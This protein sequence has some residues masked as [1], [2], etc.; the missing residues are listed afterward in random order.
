MRKSTLRLYLPFLGL[1]AAQA[2][3]ISFLPST[4]GHRTQ[5]AAGITGNAAAAAASDQAATTGDT[6]VAGGAVSGGGAT[7]GVGGGATAALGGA[8][9]T[10]AAATE[11]P[12]SKA[13]CVGPKQFGGLSQATPPCVAKF[14][15]DNG[16]ATATGVT[17]DK[18]KVIF[19]ASKPNDQVDAILAT[20]GLAVPYAETVA[21]DQAALKYVE[22][23]YELYG[24]HI[25]AEFVQGN[26][27]TTP[28]DYDTCNAEAQAVAKKK[29]FLII[30]GTS[31]YGSVFDIWANAGIV[32]FG[33]WQFD[34]SLF[35]NPPRRGLRYD[36]WMDGTQVGAHLAEYYCKKMAK[37][38]ADHSGGV[39]HPTIGSRG[40][41]PRKL[42]IITPEIEANV[43]AAKSV[44]NAVKACGGN[45]TSSP[46]TYQSD[47]EAATQQT[48]ATVTKLVQDKVTTVACMCDPI[49]PA[50][51][52]TGMSGNTYFPE[53]LL[54]GTQFTDADLVGR[55]YDPQQMQHAFG[56]STIPAQGALAN[57]D[58]TKVW[59]DVGSPP[60]AAKDTSATNPC[61]KNGCGINWSYI[62]MLGTAIQMAGPNLTPATLQQGM[63]SLPADGGWAAAHKPDVAFWKLGPND[64]TWLSDTREV[65]F[66]G[67]AVSPVDNGRCAYVG[68]NGGQ[69][70]TLGQWTPGL[71]EIPVD[72]PVCA[73]Q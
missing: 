4:G 63:L 54:T 58:A 23:H 38:N 42:G 49:A 17:K 59:R 47:I 33:G 60:A 30:W 70:Y 6:S 34:A 45:V 52:T 46:Y 31:L 72:A 26:C 66:S 50:F 48:Q 24:R 40:Q 2:L 64:Y 68:V 65:Y 9:R 43:L 36:P 55:L 22:K 41:V 12:G 51:L 32:S 5:V 13:H 35:N 71:S 67:S 16:G 7:T 18:I 10:G 11:T 8:G 1:V 19:F 57:G 39:I 44:I 69:R 28:P 56:I 73:K 62:N 14:T 61:E 20:Q 37:G 25:D 21:Y 15:G 3:L 29:P 53:F 27:P